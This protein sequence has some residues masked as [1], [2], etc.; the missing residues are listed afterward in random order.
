VTYLFK[1][2]AQN[3]RPISQEELDELAQNRIEKI[4]EL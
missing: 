1:G 3:V 4:K 2:L